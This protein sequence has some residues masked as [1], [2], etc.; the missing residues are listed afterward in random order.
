MILTERNTGEYRIYAG[1]M[2]GIHDDGFIAAVV[3]CVHRPASCPPREVFRDEAL[4]CGH[5]W[6]TSESALAFAL[7]KGQEAVAQARDV[8]RDVFLQKAA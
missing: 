4:A 7:G 1:A 6:R 3:V 5:R 2:E 8:D